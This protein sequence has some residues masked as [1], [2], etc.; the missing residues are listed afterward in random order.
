MPCDDTNDKDY[1]GS[2]FGNHKRSLLTRAVL[3]LFRNSIR[4][5]YGHAHWQLTTPR[6]KTKKKRESCGR[7]K[8][9]REED[10]VN[11]LGKWSFFT[12]RSVILRSLQG[13]LLRVCC[14]STKPH[15][16]T[17]VLKRGRSVCHLGT[18]MPRCSSAYAWSR[19]PQHDGMLVGHATT[20]YQSP[21][22]GLL[23]HPISLP[24]RIT[25]PSCLA[26]TTHGP[27]VA[28]TSLGP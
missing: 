16:A 13:S 1:T 17:F 11:V 15:V 9:P 3:S 14:A 10:T 20:M 6:T 26:M 23:S 24:A 7:P 25:L 18:K 8:A 28:D 19:S 12:M 21:G 5:Y 27:M 4:S 2:I 22:P